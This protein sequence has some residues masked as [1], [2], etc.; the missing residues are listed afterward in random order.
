M[1]VTLE[2]RD[3]IGVQRGG[4]FPEGFLGRLVVKVGTLARA[5][6]E[7]FEPL[8]IG[9]A[10]WYSERELTWKSGSL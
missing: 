8:V 4:R 6:E 9:L 7:R 3:G 10:R 2:L 5:D 1:L